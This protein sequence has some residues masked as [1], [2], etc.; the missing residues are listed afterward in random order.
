MLQRERIQLALELNL[1]TQIHVFLFFTEAGPTKSDVPLGNRVYKYELIDDNTRLANP[2]LFLHLPAWPDDS[3]VGGMIGIGPDNNVYLV[4]GDQR[5]TAFSRVDHPDS[6]TKAQNYVNGLDPDGRAGI[7][8]ITQ[9][10]GVVGSAG[11]LGDEHPLNKYYAY[12]IKNSF[13]IHLW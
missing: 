13:G 5:P 7:L 6:Q 11:V 4:V 10:G 9:D 8:Q 2:T 12:G 1:Y 3:H